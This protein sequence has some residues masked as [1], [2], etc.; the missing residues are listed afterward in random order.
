[1]VDRISNAFRGRQAG[2]KYMKQMARWRA[3]KSS[4][5]APTAQL[6]LAVGTWACEFTTARSCTFQVKF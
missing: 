2:Q 5:G 1:M 6:S 4:K 3:R